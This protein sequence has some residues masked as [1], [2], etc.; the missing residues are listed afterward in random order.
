VRDA[1]YRRRAK[2]CHPDVGGSNDAMRALNAAL[3]EVK[4]E[5]ANGVGVHT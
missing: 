1:A 5:R 3:D 2:E 4:S